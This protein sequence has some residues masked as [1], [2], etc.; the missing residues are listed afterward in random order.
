MRIFE[1]KQTEKSNRK[2]ECL[3]RIQ[4]EKNCVPGKFM[5]KKT[6]HTATGL[7]KRNTVNT[8]NR[9]R[10]KIKKRMCHRKILYSA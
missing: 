8:V 4:V 2:T 10:I 5:L 3:M 6:L 1:E 7:S 9:Q